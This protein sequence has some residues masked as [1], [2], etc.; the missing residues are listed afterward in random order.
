MA[1]ERRFL[2][3]CITHLRLRIGLYTLDKGRVLRSPDACLEL[4]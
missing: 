2:G 3:M 1:D 4:G